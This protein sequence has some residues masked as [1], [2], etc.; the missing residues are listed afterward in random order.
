M[1]TLSDDKT[2]LGLPHRTGPLRT[3]CPW[4]PLEGHRKLFTLFQS[5]RFSLHF[6]AQI[7]ASAKLFGFSTLNFFFLPPIRSRDYGHGPLA[8]SLQGLV[9]TFPS[10]FLLDEW[11]KLYKG[12]EGSLVKLFSGL[13]KDVNAFLSLSLVFACVSSILFCTKILRIFPE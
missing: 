8:R 1:A 10:D 2:I 7:F 9:T 5:T 6:G 3:R 4:T 11:C 12:K 13:W